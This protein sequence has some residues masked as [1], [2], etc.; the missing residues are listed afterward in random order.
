M[1]TILIFTPMKIENLSLLI[2]FL[3]G[4]ISC[5]TP[6]EDADQANM[7]FVLSEEGLPF[8]TLGASLDSLQFPKGSTV[9]EELITQGGYHWRV[10]TV[11]LPGDKK[12][13][14]DG[15][16]VDEGDP[17]GKLSQSK[18]NRIHIDNDA[19]P[20]Q[21]GIKVGDSFAD[22]IEKYGKENLEIIYIPAYEVID[23]SAPNSS[24]LHFNLNDNTGEIADFA[25]GEIVEIPAEK[26]S[27]ESNII[28][29][30]VL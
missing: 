28:S 12:I 2:I 7:E 20:T 8:V 11:F 1:L 16:F 6:S 9:E 3:L 5:G 21:D 15:D 27:L 25:G 26:V 19:Y 10:L 30:V 22:L 29:I 17:A 4:I 13:K 24:R 23:I 18:V 14:I